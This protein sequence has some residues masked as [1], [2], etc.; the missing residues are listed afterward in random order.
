[1][2]TISIFFIK[3]YQFIFSPDHGV[4]FPNRARTCRFYP[5]CSEYTIESLKKYGFLKGFWYGARRIGRCH[6]WQEGGYDPV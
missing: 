1:M 5:S 3:T 6:P 4:L 2:L